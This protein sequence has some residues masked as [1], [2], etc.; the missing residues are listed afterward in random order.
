MN[1]YLKRDPTYQRPI[2]CLNTWPL[3]T[4]LAWLPKKTN[5]KFLKGEIN[6]SSHQSSRT[7]IVILKALTIHDNWGGLSTPWLLV[8]PWCPLLPPKGTTQLLEG[9]DPPAHRH[10][11]SL[12]ELLKN[13]AK[14]KSAGPSA[15][16]EASERA[17]LRFGKKRELGHWQWRRECQNSVIQPQNNFEQSCLLIC[18]CTTMKPARASLLRGGRWSSTFSPSVSMLA[19]GRAKYDS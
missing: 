17:L 13:G 3:W 8:G 4:P 1:N 12:A 19:G 9:T 5:L 10:A 18:W 14:P 7:Y 11:R 16:D 2:A 15:A 6:D